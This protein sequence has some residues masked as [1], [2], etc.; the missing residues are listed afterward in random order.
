M[1]LLKVYE[2][3][4]HTLAYLVAEDHTI[5]LVW[6]QLLG[7]PRQSLGPDTAHNRQIW[8]G[9]LSLEWREISHPVH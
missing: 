3:H 1:V 2:K 9:I 4:P 7:G 5:Y 6:N 8:D